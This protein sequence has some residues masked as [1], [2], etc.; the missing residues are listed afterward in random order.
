MFKVGFLDGFKRL[1]PWVLKLR[2]RRELLSTVGIW[3]PL[4]PEIRL[5][6]HEERTGRFAHKIDSPMVILWVG[7][8]SDKYADSFVSLHCVPNDNCVIPC[9]LVSTASERNL[10]QSEREPT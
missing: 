10:R 6:S 2:D 7:Q 3:M 1:S 9:S 5:S 4:W 8:Q